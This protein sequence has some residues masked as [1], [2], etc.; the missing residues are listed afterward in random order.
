MAEGIIDIDQIVLSPTGSEKT[1]AKILSSFDLRGPIILKPNWSSS[2]IFTEKQVL[3]WILSS[4]NTDVVVVE[5]YAMWRNELFLEAET[6]D[7][8]LLMQLRKQRK[9]DL[10][11]NDR[12]FLEWSG[13]AEVLEKHDVEYLN[14]SEELWAKRVCVADQIQKSVARR[15]PPLVIEDLAATVPTRLHDL[16]GGTLISL[17]KP[18]RSLGANFVSLSMKNMFGMIPTPYRRKYHG[19]NEELLSHSIIDINKIYHSLFNVMGV[20]EGIFST[21]E[22]IGNPMTPVIHRN[23]GYV[24]ASTSLLALDALIAAQL[25]LDPRNV[26]YLLA[27]M[28]AFGRW[29]DDIVAYGRAHPVSF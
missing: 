19:D 2:M 13:I 5:S 3:D 6:R 16:R 11:R 23:A 9:N 17:A 1:L 29:S 28:D 12:W 26:D 10:R 15:Y 21:S 14:I 7:G 22:T 18:K 27:S 8:E 25:G 4:L 24:W 20:V